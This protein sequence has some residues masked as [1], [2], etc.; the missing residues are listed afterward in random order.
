MRRGGLAQGANVI[1]S[2]F[3]GQQRCFEYFTWIN[4]AAPMR[5][6]TRRQLGALENPINRLDIKFLGQN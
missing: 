2:A 3:D 6:V 4:F 1:A 5:K